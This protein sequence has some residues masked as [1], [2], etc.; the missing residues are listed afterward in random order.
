M[1]DAGQVILRTPLE[2]LANEL[3]EVVKLFYHIDGFSVNPEAVE[4]ESSLLIRHRF[5]RAGME[6]RCAFAIGEERQEK[7]LLLPTVEPERQELIEKRLIKRLCKVTLY[8]L[9]K[10]L[11]GQRP[12]WGS[13]TGIRPTRLIY[14]GLADGLTMDEACA[15]VEDLFAEIL[16]DFKKNKN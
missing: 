16:I 6:C 5:E 9:L 12:P 13:L 3:C 7:T 2:G 8:E 15:R 4:G 11:T 1:K 10:R 14:E